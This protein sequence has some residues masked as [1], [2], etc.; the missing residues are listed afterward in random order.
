MR[1]SVG[2]NWDPAL[3]EALGQ[4][5]QVHDL[6][7]CLPSHVVGHGRP[8]VS[9]P[10]VSRDDIAQHIRQ[11]HRAGMTFT[12]LLNAPGMG[13]RQFE[14]RYRKDILEHLDW[15]C[16]I[17]VDS[18]TVSI[19]DLAQLIV[20]RYPRLNVKISHNSYV[21]T[22]EQALIFQELGASMI[23]LH[24]TA[25]RNFHLMAKLTGNL[26][27]PL[28]IICTIDCMPGC[29]NSIGYHMSATSTLSSTRALPDQHNRHSSGY[30]FSWCHLK[31][32][33]KPEE[34][35]KGGFVRPEDLPAYEQA[36]I[37]EFKL[38]TRV[39]TTAHILDRVR[40]YS[41]GSYD[42]DLKRLLSVFSLGY[43]TR[44]GGQMGTGTAGTGQGQPEVF[45][46]LGSHVDFDAV[47]NLDNSALEHFLEMFRETG[48]N[49]DCESCNYCVFFAQ[50]A[51][52]W[53]EPERDKI[54]AL[55]T[56]YRTWLLNR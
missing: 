1:L 48:C 47:L 5:E 22:L 8:A 26:S 23:T 4:V 46:E 40:A 42:G 2:T 28:Q 25:T 43:K 56:D 52:N 6:F 49:M 44:A 41:S 30:C 38:D 29:P 19:T 16:E 32:L 10:Q 37:H 11:V 35:L 54:V 3:V 50:E 13:G 20:E 17:K 51:M 7:G 39:L 36:G 9:V 24:Q 33:E 34:I 15:L 55:L 53:N 21:R 18:V 14:P 12:Y 27:I 31:K 45:F